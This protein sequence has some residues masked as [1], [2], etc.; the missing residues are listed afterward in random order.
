MGGLVELDRALGIHA[1]H[2]IDDTDGEVEMG[3]RIMP[4]WPAT[5][6]RLTSRRPSG[7]PLYFVHIC[8]ADPFGSHPKQEK[9]PCAN[10]VR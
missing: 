2:A 4:K 5:Q 10:F 6:E 1:E 3:V 9:V 7:I 8:P